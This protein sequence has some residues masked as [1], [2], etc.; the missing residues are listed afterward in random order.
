MIRTG[1]PSVFRKS[2]QA[3]AVSEEVRL[4]SSFNATSLVFPDADAVAWSPVLSLKSLLAGVDTSYVS[5]VPAS[6]ERRSCPAGGMSKTSAVSPH[7][8]VGVMRTA[9]GSV[10]R[11]S[12]HA[13]DTSGLA[14]RRSSVSDTV[15]V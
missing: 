4:G 15:L 12:I 7:F 10:L 5:S 6:N 2:I 11:K 8:P 14:F 1:T 3:V 9:T 13:G